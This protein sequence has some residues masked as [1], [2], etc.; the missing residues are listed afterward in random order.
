MFLPPTQ[1]PF[2]FE[3]LP[4]QYFANAVKIQAVT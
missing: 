3:Y 4:I 1:G 2:N